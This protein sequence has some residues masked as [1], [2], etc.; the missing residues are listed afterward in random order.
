MR[1]QLPNL[2]TLC[3]LLMGCLAIYSTYSYP[4]VLG[5][6]FLFVLLATLFDTLDGFVARALK[7]ESPLGAQ[8]DSLSDVVSFGVAPA[9]VISK[10]FDTLLLA[11]P[12]GLF[13]VV[14]LFLP[15]LGGAFRLARFNCGSNSSS[16]FEGMPI[17]A[18]GLFWLGYA[19]IVEV[20][21]L[22]ETI[23]IEP[24]YFITLFFSLVMMG[25]M[26]SRFPFLS[27]KGLSPRTRQG[28]VAIA[29]WAGLLICLIVMSI[30]LPLRAV[31][32]PF[33]LLY[34]IVSLLFAP[35]SR[36]EGAVNKERHLK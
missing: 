33:I 18:N 28:R 5:L 9:I 2:L 21:L 1:K 32:A 15:T 25:L 11:N 10:Q 27:L 4:S 34:A 6:P 35:Y 8:L 14:G 23:A 17:P 31:L 26:T 16:F 24:L 19:F 13:M 36:R 12:I 7:A 30:V 20:L 22:S 29:L 3:N